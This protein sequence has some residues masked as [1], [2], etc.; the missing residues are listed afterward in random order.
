MPLSNF[1]PESLFLNS[2]FGKFGNCSRK[3]C[4]TAFRF[5]IVIDTDG[6]LWQSNSA[7]RWKEEKQRKLVSRLNN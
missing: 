2:Y 7:I 5:Y 3:P 1:L 4:W 6:L